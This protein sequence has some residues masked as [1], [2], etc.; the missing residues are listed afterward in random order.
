MSDETTW[1]I[2]I[3]QGIPFQQ[4]HDFITGIRTRSARTG[5]EF[6]MFGLRLTMAGIWLTMFEI[7]IGKIIVRVSLDDVQ[8]NFSV[9][10]S[11]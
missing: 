3:F 11:P 10:P 9:N 6:L 7:I 4:R 2:R 5:Y 1:E 8:E